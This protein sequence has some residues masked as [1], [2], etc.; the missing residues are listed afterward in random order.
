MKQYSIG[1]VS[2]L[3]QIPKSTL[4][5]WDAENLIQLERNESNDYRV[6][7]LRELLTIIDVSL[8]RNLKM[9][10]KKLKKMY[11]WDI[12]TWESIMC[13]EVQVV[14]D[15]INKLNELRKSLLE[16][17]EKIQQVTQLQNQPFIN[18]LPDIDYVISY[19]MDDSVILNKSRENV[20][21]FVIYIPADMNANDLIPIYGLAVNTISE[22]SQV[23]WQSNNKNQ[24]YVQCLLKVSREEPYESNLSEIRKEL[25]KQGYKTGNIIGRFLVHAKESVC[26][27]YY[28]V[29][30]EVF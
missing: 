9:P 8:Y 23:L 7:T 26:F 4:R 24:S 5:Y 30:V 12:D 15:K 25:H 29:W 11:Q 13:E 1:E 10:V 21:D 18:S 6:Y 17:K 16:R 2:K 22:T 20:Y 14:D 3:F 27:D 19:D 28:K